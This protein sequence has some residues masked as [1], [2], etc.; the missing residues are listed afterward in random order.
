MRCCIIIQ[1]H[2]STCMGIGHWGSYS[3]NLLNLSLSLRWSQLQVAD[4]LK[5]DG[6]TKDA[7]FCRAMAY[8]IKA[9][10]ERGIEG[11]SVT[12]Y[13]T[14]RHY[15]SSVYTYGDWWGWDFGYRRAIKWINACERQVER[16]QV[17]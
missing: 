4:E 12:V 14:L 5:K 6:F 13:F 11:Q 7:E 17:E 2:A 8:F 3:E 10:D 9:T 15:L 16:M 1:Y